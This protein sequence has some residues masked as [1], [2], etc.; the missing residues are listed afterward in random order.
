MRNPLGLITLMSA[1][2]LGWS[3]GTP[4]AKPVTPI[5]AAKAV[6]KPTAIINTTAGKLTCELFP[7]KAPIGVANFV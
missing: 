1:A 6:V 3:Q 4:P 7:D 5:A 2:T